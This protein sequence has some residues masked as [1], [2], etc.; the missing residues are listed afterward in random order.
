M[1]AQ[2]NETCCAHK[3][4]QRRVVSGDWFTGRFLAKI[5]TDDL[6]IDFS[7]LISVKRMRY[8]NIKEDVG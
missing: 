2:F 5:I 6:D 1:I 4:H 3:L 8:I 7:K